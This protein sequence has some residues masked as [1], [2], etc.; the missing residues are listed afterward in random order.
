MLGDTEPMSAQDLSEQVGSKDAEVIWAIERRAYSK[1][2]A[3]KSD[4]I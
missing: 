3:R 1:C 2:R 4:K